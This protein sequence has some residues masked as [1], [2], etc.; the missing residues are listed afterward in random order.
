MSTPQTA[1]P[2]ISREDLLRAIEIAKELERRQV[3]NKLAY[4]KAYPF[5][6]RFHATGLDASQRLLMAANRVGKS[7]TGAMELAMH[8]TGLYPEDW[9]GRRFIRK[10]ILAWACGASTETTRDI[11]Q[12]ELVGESSDPAAWGTG[13]I[14]KHLIVDSTRKPGVPNAKN[15]VTVKH[16]S[17]GISRLVFKSYEMGAEKFMGKS[18]DI[19]WLDE[20]PPQSIYTQC[21]TRTTNTHGMVYLTFTPEAGMT[22][23]VAQFTND[24]R[25]GQS[26]TTASWDDAPHL[27]EDAKT[28][29]L[30]ALPEWERDMRSKGIP[31]LGSGLVYPV[32]EEDISVEPFPI[33]DH[34]PK[35]CGLD[36]G[37]DHPSAAV[38]VA[39]DRDEDVVY[40]Y[41]SYR[42]SHRTPEEHAAEI[43][44]R[45]NVPVVWPHDGN[46]RDGMGG[47]TLR[48]Q[49][50]K[51]GVNMLLE[52]FRNPLAVGEK[53]GSNS[54]EAGIMD[55][56][57]RMKSGRFKIFRTLNE[58]WE[59]FRMYHRKEGK[60]IE[61]HD[62][63]MDAMRYA[64]LSLERG[65]CV[66][67]D[68]RWSSDIKYESLGII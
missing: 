7:F 63:L 17:G 43:N 39:W 8:L 15:S 18:V 35:I 57:D 42:A 11:V 56:L 50:A 44:R 6:S 30:A 22:D 32:P 31:L 52:H 47:P 23:V 24:L 61:K 3:E 33:P 54:V 10:P 55:V 53:K 51:C 20:E 58:V 19:I 21:V 62:D 37:W 66:G 65:E 59:E 16:S 67:E 41:D 64:A 5:Q 12:S 40:V 2:N 49:F 48:D 4:Y 38:W 45:A 68:N 9:N 46:R 25:R 14:P 13:S 60:R 27:D 28:Q 1:H 34:W 29:I 26:L 36:F